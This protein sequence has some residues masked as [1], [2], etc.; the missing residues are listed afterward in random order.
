[1]NILK[2]SKQDLKDREYLEQ[3]F[4]KKF[5]YNDIKGG[6]LDKHKSVMYKEMDEKAR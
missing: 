4:S 1:M 3:W 2:V 6:V 5:N